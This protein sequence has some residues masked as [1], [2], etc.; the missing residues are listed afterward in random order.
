MLDSPG[1]ELRAVGEPESVEHLRH[2]IRGGPDG[3]D[4]FLCDLPVGAATGDQADD[5][6]LT[7]SEE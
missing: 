2:V 5:L 4:Q 1:G 7:G 6:P 3:D